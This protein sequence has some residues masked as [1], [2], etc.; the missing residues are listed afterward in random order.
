MNAHPPRA[1]GVRQRNWEGTIVSYAGVE[2]PRPRTVDDLVAIMK[3]PARYPGPVRAAGSNHSTTA[4]ATAPGGT[5]VD[6][7]GMAAILEHGPDYVRVQAGAQYLAIANALRQKGQQLHINTEI[8]NLTAGSAACCG[9]K[10]GS[11]GEEPGQICSHV[12]AVK[13]VT[14]SGKPVEI[15]EARHPRLMRLVRSSYGLLGIIYEVT[16]RVTPL[17]RLRVRHESY[18]LERFLRKLPELKERH[19]SIV[20]FI[21]PHIRTVTVELR[22]YTDD[23][24]PRRRW[25]WK[26]RNFFWRDAAPATAHVITRY[27]PFRR[28]RAWLM[29]A[30]S[31]TLQYGVELLLR[32]DHTSPPDQIIDYRPQGDVPAYTFSMWAFPA[33]RYPEILRAYV[34][35]C[36]DHAKEKRYRVNLLTVGY[37][38]AGDGSSLLSY[39]R[40]GTIFSLDP[41]STG[42][43]GWHEFLRAFNEFSSAHGGIPLLNQTDAVTPVQARRAFGGRLDT[44]ERWRRRF[45]PEDRL[46]NPYFAALLHAPPLAAPALAGGSRGSIG[47][48]RPNTTEP[49]TTAPV[50]RRGRKL[51][52]FGRNVRFRAER[53]TPRNEAEL[54][55]TLA[56]HAGRRIQAIGSL[57]SWSPV[58]RADDVVID[59][60]HFDSV[61]VAPDGATVT[62]G[63][64][65]RI[66][67]LLRA[68]AADPRELTLPTI[69][70]ITKQTIA[71]AISTG[72]HGAGASSLSHH[73]QAL[74]IVTYD[75]AGHPIARAITQDDPDALRA[76]R[77]G[78]GSLGIIVSVTLSCV[79]AYDVEETPALVSSLRAVVAEAERYPLQLFTI[80]P[81]AWQAYV[82]RRRPV[83][84]AAHRPLRARAK[85]AAYRLHG[86]GMVDVTMHGLVSVLARVGWGRLTRGFYRRVIPA[87]ALRGVTVTDA[88]ERMLTLRHDLYRHV[89][90]EVFVPAAALNNALAIVRHLTDAF[91]GVRDLPPDVEALLARHAPGALADLGRNRGR[92]THHYVIPCRRVL[93][94]DTLISMTANGREAYA[95]G[96]FSYRGLE[97]GYTTYCRAI[98]LAL[99][100]LHG[101]RLHWG[102]Y[103]PMTHEEAVR[104]AYP[105]LARFHAVR[106]RLDA[107]DAFGT[108]HTRA[109]LG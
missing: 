20:L 34:D 71:G 17:R 74:R 62:V 109:A 2:P 43:L 60:R 46:L 1:P 55:A 42:D 59:L 61:E 29:N 91:A 44:L 19:Q 65:C 97:P 57:H 21:F 88:S 40:D 98:A 22:D 100:A 36:R 26:V 23:G 52:N 99:V 13:M 38:V 106:A 81:Y 51:A 27:V 7:R 96:F 35:F 25:V 37:R 49:A 104:D 50:A 4:C 80:I 56:H 53:L 16:F 54:L 87:V 8:G 14:P 30:A 28:P 48:W 75:A 58:A 78:L 5:V 83:A 77:C 95:I 89:E 105:D 108:A 10:D 41:V 76:A 33:D 9:T 15:T 11:F 32:G 101:A 3:D 79:P 12:I 64:G 82:F 72:T 31:W 92:Y 84:R 103:F 18:Q 86:R 39:S 68:L 85:A 63:G 47:P 24:V 69:G 70:A 66:G 107:A 93:A 73:V 94:D 90:M 45:D 102:K 6:M 67:R